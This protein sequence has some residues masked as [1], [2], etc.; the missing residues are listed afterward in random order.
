M[1]TSEALQIQIQVDMADRAMAMV[2]GVAMAAVIMFMV[3]VIM[4]MV[5]VIMA[6]VALELV[7]NVLLRIIY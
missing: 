7:L 1:I 3:E 6:M 5:E 2:A 4:A